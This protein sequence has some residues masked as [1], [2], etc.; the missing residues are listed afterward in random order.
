MGL[1]AKRL[2]ESH[3]LIDATCAESETLDFGN[4][5]MSARSDI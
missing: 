5:A 4:R 3:R 1:T 2:G